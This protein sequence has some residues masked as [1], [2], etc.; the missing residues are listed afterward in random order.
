MRKSQPNRIK[1]TD[2]HAKLRKMTL[3][4]D[5]TLEAAKIEREELIGMIN[6]YWQQQETEYCYRLLKDL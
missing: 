1:V 2:I 3:A 5:V 4:F 6:K